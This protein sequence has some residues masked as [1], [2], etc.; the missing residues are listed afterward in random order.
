MSETR[1]FAGEN[2]I[3]AWLLARSKFLRNHIKH[4]NEGYRGS[5]SS[6]QEGFWDRSAEPM[7]EQGAQRPRA[8][9]EAYPTEAQRSQLEQRSAG[10]V[11]SPPDES[12]ISSPR[13][14]AHDGATELPATLATPA[15]EEERTPFLNGRPGSTA[16]CCNWLD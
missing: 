16:A 12:V 9:L 5:V 1:S 14:Y 13:E 7:S 11:Y 2:R 4:N 10:S 8:P 3:D 6:K 15:Y